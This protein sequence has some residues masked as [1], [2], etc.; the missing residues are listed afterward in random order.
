ML[1]PKELNLVS[2]ILDIPV[3]GITDVEKELIDKCNLQG[4]VQGSALKAPVHHENRVERYVRNARLQLCPQC[5]CFD[6]ISIPIQ[7]EIPGIALPTQL[8]ARCQCGWEGRACQ[9]IQIDIELSRVTD[10]RH[11]KPK[12]ALPLSEPGN[13]KLNLGNEHATSRPKTL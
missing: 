7:I 8:N 11:S 2:T 10:F 13:R 12:E 3:A 1:S 6:A 4:L 5:R 9:L